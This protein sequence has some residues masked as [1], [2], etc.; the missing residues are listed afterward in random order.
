MEVFDFQAKAVSECLRAVDDRDRLLVQAPTGSGKT[1]ISQLAIAVYA[2]ELPDRYPR[3]LVIVPSRGLLAQ[4]FYDAGWLRSRHLAL[5]MLDSDLEVHRFGTLLDSY[6]VFFSTPVTLNNRLQYFSEALAG[7]DLVIFDEI[8]TY[9]TVDELDERRD[10]WPVLQSVLESGLPVVGFTG[11]NLE[12]HQLNAWEGRAFATYQAEV[13]ADWMPQTRV[14]FLGIDD[15]DV[16]L[17]DAAIR[18]DLSK[19]FGGLPGG[20]NMTWGAIKALAREGDKNALAVLRLCGERL[21]L[22]ESPG[23]NLQKYERLAEDAVRRGPCL[24]MSRYVDVAQALESVL[25]ARLP[26]RQIDG[27]QPREQIRSGMEWFRERPKGEEAALVMTRD[28]G[29]RGLDFP[30]AESVLFVSPRSNYQTVAQEIARIRSRAGAVKQSTIYFYAGTEEQAKAQRLAAHMQ[31]QTFRDA[32][33]FELADPPEAVELRD[34]E[35]RNM[36]YEESL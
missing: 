13:P 27:Q 9:L 35:S 7:F 21:R 31:A 34:F 36:A 14:Q 30:A 5:H 19:A 18:E 25:S 33:L 20:S 11:T 6:G 12:Q 22:F 10:T 2:D 24:V 29:G 1:L 28:L 15:P 26:T 23:S 3:A 8:D 17:Q 16:I 32:N 4:H